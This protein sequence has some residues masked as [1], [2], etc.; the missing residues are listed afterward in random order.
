MKT[1]VSI[2]N[3]SIRFLFT[4]TFRIDNPPFMPLVI[5]GI[6]AGPR[7][8]PVISVTHYGCK[9]A[10]PCATPKSA[11]R[12][13]SVVSLSGSSPQSAF[14]IGMQGGGSMTSTVTRRADRRALSLLLS[15][16]LHAH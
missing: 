7:G 3:A 8:L 13:N 11:L 1:V 12:P 14:M 5:E 16:R 2:L 10:M 9:T 4:S 15:Q 6:G